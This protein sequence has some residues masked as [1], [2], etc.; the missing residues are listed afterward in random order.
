MSDDVAKRLAALEARVE[1]L[2]AGGTF[3]PMRDTHRC[4]SCGGR[5]ILFVSKL[6]S[7]NGWPLHVSVADTFRK[8][9]DGMVQVYVCAACGHGELQLDR[10]GVLSGGGGGVV[11]LDE[12]PKQGP[13][14]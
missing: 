1:A 5:K 9:L 14:R 3:R 6:Y 2:E 11:V 7:Y 13:Y 4:P 12:D 10:A 8:R